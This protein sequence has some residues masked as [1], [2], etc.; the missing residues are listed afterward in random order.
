[1]QPTPKVIYEFGPFRLD[2]Q[3]H[4]LFKTGQPV[5]LPPKAFDILTLLLER[6]DALVS[7]TDLLSRIWPHAF[8]E[9]NNLAQH[10]SLLRKTLGETREN[11]Q[12][13]ETLPR[14]GYRFIGEVREVQD[15]RENG[16]SPAAV[17]LPGVAAPE[18]GPRRANLHR[19]FL[20]LPAAA[21]ALAGLGIFLF[22]RTPAPVLLNHGQ[23]THDGYP[24]YGPLMADSEFVYFTEIRNGAR[25]LVRVPAAG[26]DPFVLPAD[27]PDLQALDLSPARGEIL[28]LQAG[29]TG[30]E[31]PLFAGNASN[32]KYR[33][34]D[35]IQANSAAWSP[36]GDRIFY[37]RGAKLYIAK[38]DGSE[39]RQLMTAGGR[40]AWL[41]VSPGGRWL[42]F[43]IH[44]DSGSSDELWQARTDG[45]QMQCISAELSTAVAH[46]VAAW[47]PDAKYL[48]F[49][50]TDESKF[51]LSGFKRPRF[52]SGLGTRFHL[53]SGLLNVTALAA[54]IGGSRLFAI[55]TLDRMGIF[56]LDKSSNLAPYMRGI[57]AD[58]LAFT[59]QGD[60]VAYAT[61][62]DRRLMRSRL[63]GSSR[64]QLTSPSEP[65]L[66]PSW[67]PDGSRIAYMSR[68]GSGPWKIFLISKDGGK[69]EELSPS[70]E[71][72]STPTWSPGGSSIIFAGAP[73]VKGFAPNSTPIQQVDVQTK[74]VT[75]LPDSA[76]LWSPRW[77]PNGKYLVAETLDSQRLLLFH[78]S[79]GAWST[80]AGPQ[81][82]VIG[83]TSWSHD[84]RYV[85]FNR[86]AHQRG[87]IYRVDVRTGATEQ[88]WASDEQGMAATLGQWFA[89][90]PDDSPLLLR[91]TSVH[92]LFAVDLHLP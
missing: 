18:S 64:L 49:S 71:D 66:M 15:G 81:K 44:R 62:P 48:F 9:E 70:P 57:S 50:E 33:R 19:T 11:P 38:P 80:L 25:V 55:E 59:R 32:G 21:L 27:P 41:V 7:K 37:A 3:R 79:T 53:N 65:A 42:T 30:A 54:A 89:L 10:V 1:M 4:A 39:S 86:Y 13:I 76:G 87:S 72:Q 20:L 36:G 17:L 56:R 46:P 88:V 45:T 85:Y 77:S 31:L 28:A 90:A 40:V 91:D 69:P 8:V 12:Y 14:I 61:Y 22:Q 26:G 35:G 60:W 51:W 29:P 34:V 24:K 92:E 2:P 16:I 74:R 82:E 43:E 68:S 52:G 23:L 47:T 83:Y 75:T 5:S 63:D 67:S 6:R 73:W 78:F 58:G 84:S